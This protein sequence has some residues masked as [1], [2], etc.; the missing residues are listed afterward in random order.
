MTHR[1]KQEAGM[2]TGEHYS[3][4]LVQASLHDVNNLQTERLGS[5]YGYIYTWM[6]GFFYIFYF[7]RTK[8]L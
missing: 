2:T 8:I 1:Q 5:A 4:K 7:C 6:D 3:H